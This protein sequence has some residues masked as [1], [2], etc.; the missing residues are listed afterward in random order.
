MKQEFNIKLAQIEKDE[1][2]LEAYRTNDNTVVLAG[3][4]SGKTTILTLKIMRLLSE[5]INEPR[6]IAC[7]TYSREA[8]REFKERLIKI[9]LPNR[10]NIFLGTVHSFCLAEVI[11]PYSKLYPQYNIPSP[12]KLIS[13]KEKTS[14]FDRLK[15]EK[16]ANTDILK[17]DRE[18][19]RKIEGLSKI[20]TPID[21]IASELGI[22]YENELEKLGLIDYI[23]IVKYA[24][25]LIQNEEYV[26]ICLEAK[27]P[28]IIIDEY[29]DLGK[30]L[31]EMVLSLITTTKM[32]YFVVGDP[33]QSIY[34][35]QGASPEYLLEL[36]KDF[37][38][39]T[40]ILTNNY[41]SAEKIIK[42][43]E[44]VLGEKRNYI[45]KGP[46]KDYTAKIEFVSCECEISEQ[47]T[48]VVKRIHVDYQKGMP[49]HEMA[50]LCGNKYQISDVCKCLQENSIDFYVSKHPFEISDMIKW[51]QKCAGWVTEQSVSFDEIYSFWCRINN[52]VELLIDEKI[53]MLKRQLYKVMTESAKHQ[54]S[55]K[56][57][58]LY[59]F[60]EL[61]IDQLLEEID[62]LPDENDN[63]IILKNSL[64]ILPYKEYSLLDFYNMT[65]PN[66]QVI[67]STR[68]GSKGLE[69]DVIYMIGM[70][71]G[72][73]PYYRCSESEEKESCRI[74]FVCV[75]RARKKCVLL[76][77][78]HITI[79]TKNGPWTKDCKPNRFWKMLYQGRDCK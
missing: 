13:N 23:S 52:N 45:A 66:N 6:G 53:M 68:H 39:H 78:K 3:P 46:L 73:F 60:E 29:Q 32:K 38:I 27:F 8:A 70:E 61:A 14:I 72:N 55:I 18:R 40:I 57:W 69:F 71:E 21:N 20:S 62:L 7:V 24:T 79:N 50:I 30:P 56:A 22:S 47:V 64:E 31:H 63:I 76:Y 25:M 15:T 58:I 54:K 41:R 59:I 48:E 67:V 33:D 49:Y 36:G 2:Q 51:F 19:T 77:S 11:F 37:S 5:M 10:K 1:K 17:M 75:S 43:S 65:T 26:R 74:C 28:W 9:G 35:F 34:D 16:G 42:A 12:I 44:I 4:G